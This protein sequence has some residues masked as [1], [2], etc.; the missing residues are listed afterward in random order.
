[1]FNEGRGND[2]SVGLVVV[3]NGVVCFEKKNVFVSSVWS[4]HLLN[5]DDSGRVEMEGT[6]LE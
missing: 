3:V 5:F 1:M 2:Q 6:H 4:Q